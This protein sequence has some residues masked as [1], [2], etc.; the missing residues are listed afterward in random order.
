ME[1]DINGC[2]RVSHQRTAPEAKHKD[3]NL[4]QQSAGLATPRALSQATKVSD[5]PMYC[6]FLQPCM[7]RGLVR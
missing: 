7:T 5:P 6:T 3:F 2:A 4:Y 1:Q